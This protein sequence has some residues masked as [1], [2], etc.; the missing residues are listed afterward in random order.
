[1]G[2]DFDDDDYCR[3]TILHICTIYSRRHSIRLPLLCL[4]ALLTFSGCTPAPTYRPLEPGAVVLA[5]GDSITYG[6]GAGGELP[7]PVLLAELTG[8]QVVNAGIPGDTADKARQRLQ[9]LLDQHQPELVIVELGGNDFLRNRPESEVKR[10]LQ[11][12][13]QSIENHGSTAVLVA[14]PRLSVLRATTGNLA[15]APLYAELAAE[16]DILLVE[17]LLS[18][19]L[20]EDELRA[21]PIHPNAGGYRNLA[22]GVADRLQEAGFW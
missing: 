5:F 3:D 13:L 22:T 14:V 21:D 4:A 19:I 16:Q 17:D 6:T 12:M 7:Y 15:D 9:P 11:E 1:M 2:N 18:D 20:S 10:H 8:W